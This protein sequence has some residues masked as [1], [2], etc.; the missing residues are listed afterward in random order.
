MHASLLH[1]FF[2]CVP[3]AIAKDCLKL[4]ILD[5][6]LFFG[7]R[8]QSTIFFERSNTCVQRSLVLYVALSVRYEPVWLILMILTCDP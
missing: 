3:L 6:G 7:V 8:G 2:F 5:L 1:E 4:E